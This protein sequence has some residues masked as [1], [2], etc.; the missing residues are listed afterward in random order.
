[1]ARHKDL[2][3]QIRAYEGDI[4]SLNSQADRLVASGVTSLAIGGNTANTK[5]QGIENGR[6]EPDGEWGEEIRMIPEEYSEEESCERTEY[7]TV[8]EERLVPQVKA[9][10]AFEGQ[11]MTMTK[12]EVKKLD[13]M[14]HWRCIIVSLIALTFI[15][16]TFYFFFFMYQVFF[17]LNKTNDD[18]WHVRKGS[19]KD[20]FVPA[21]YVK[22]IEGKRIPVQVRQPFT[23]KDV[24]RIKKTRMAKKTVPIRKPKPPPK[25]VG[26][27]EI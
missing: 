18:W 8:T 4:Q 12:G 16:S 21:N 19:G 3:G 15:F 27:L 25:A 9:I 5:Q 24:R 17:L 20:G 11:G 22:E 23:V 10:Y 13:M 7:R 1:L 26:P 2:E 6:G 14:T